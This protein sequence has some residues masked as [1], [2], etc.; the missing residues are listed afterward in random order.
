MLNKFLD[1]F[2]GF[3]WISRWKFAKIVIFPIFH[4]EIRQTPL[5]ISKNL[6][7]VYQGLLRPQKRR[8]IQLKIQ[9]FDEVIDFWWKI[10]KIN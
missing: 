7:N 4:L 9:K 1:I 3:D 6:K 5:K 10:A 2:S 8:L